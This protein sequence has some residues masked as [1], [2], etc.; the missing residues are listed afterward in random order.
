M[1]K[2]RGW[3]KIA[4][5]AGLAILVLAVLISLVSDQVLDEL[6]FSLSLWLIIAVVLIIN[7][8]SVLSFIVMY[9]IYRW[10]KQDFDPE[11]RQDR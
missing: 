7:I 9:S 3:L 5:A 10:I 2:K 1:N 8:I 11:D 4:F 6:K